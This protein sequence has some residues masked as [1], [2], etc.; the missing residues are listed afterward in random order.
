M[1]GYAAWAAE[2]AQKAGVRFVDLNTITANKYDALGEEATRAYFNDVQHS[3][4]AGARL[5]AESVAAGIGSLKDCALAAD[6]AS[7]VKP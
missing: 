1:D 3:R 6:L 5:N 2:T 4:K 7:G